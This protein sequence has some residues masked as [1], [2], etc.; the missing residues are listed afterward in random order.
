MRS[1]LQAGPC[2]IC[3]CCGA[4]IELVGWGRETARSGNVSLRVH[5]ASLVKLLRTT[6]VSALKSATRLGERGR[7]LHGTSHARGDAKLS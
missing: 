6:Q 7:S 3:A 5:S 4:D 2:V 1:D